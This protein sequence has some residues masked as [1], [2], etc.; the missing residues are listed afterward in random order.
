VDFWS[1]QWLWGAIVLY[2][3]AA[4]LSTA[5]LGPGVRKLVALGKDGRAGTPEF[6]SLVRVQQR[7]GPVTSV[8]VLVIIVLMVWK[9]GG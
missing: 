1:H 5:V 4:G 6:T 7:I 2:I 9:P 3:I 8:I